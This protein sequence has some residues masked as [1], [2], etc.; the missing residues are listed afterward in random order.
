MGGYLVSP[1]PSLA[2]PFDPDKSQPLATGGR[3]AWCA[4]YSMS[5]PA[6]YWTAY[7]G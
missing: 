6:E 7:A 4:R 3:R 5:S 2:I 1:S